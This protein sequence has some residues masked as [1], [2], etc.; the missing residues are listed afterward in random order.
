MTQQPYPQQQPQQQADPW[1][2]PTGSSSLFS[3]SDHA[4]AVIL[5]AVRA[6]H[7]QMQGS[8]GARDAVECGVDIVT[9]QRNPQFAGQRYE[10]VL[11]YGVALVDELKDKAGQYVLGRLLA[12]PSKHASPVIVLEEAAPFEADQARQHVARYGLQDL[13][14]KPP[15]QIAAVNQQHAQAFQQGQYNQQPQQQYAPQQGGG[16]GQPPPWSAPQQGGGGPGQAVPP[17]GPPPP[18]GYGQQ[19]A[20]PN[21]QPSPVQPGPQQPADPP[22]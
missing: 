18:S 6:F 3:P 9:E 7:P 1:T 21:Y 12:K 10:D 20:Q 8:F 5:I 2:N 17:P 14:P 11:L 4:G 19:P 22:F 16:V 13:A 15:E